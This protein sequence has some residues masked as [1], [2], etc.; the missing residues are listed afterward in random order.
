MSH[1]F[2]AF[3]SAAYTDSW[4]CAPVPSRLDYKKTAG[5]PL[6]RARFTTKDNMHLKGVVTGLGSKSSLVIFAHYVVLL[7]KNKNLWFLEG[8]AERYLDVVN[9]LLPLEWRSW[10]DWPR[11]AIR[12]EEMHDIVPLDR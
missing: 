9:T 7:N 12:G 5:R 6:S 11:H 3:H 8:L 10:L 2:E 4:R 1:R